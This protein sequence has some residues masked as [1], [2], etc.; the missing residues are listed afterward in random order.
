MYS[1]G[2]AFGGCGR[3][4]FGLCALWAA[5]FSLPPAES[6]EWIRVS[7]S[8]LFKTIIKHGQ[9]HSL[10]SRSLETVIRWSRIASIVVAVA[11]ASR[12]RGVHTRL[13]GRIRP[14]CCCC[15]AICRRRI[16]A[17]VRWWS[18]CGIVTECATIRGHRSAGSAVS[19]RIVVAVGRQAVVVA[20]ICW[21]TA[22]VA[23]GSWWIC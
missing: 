14:R 16:E 11:A 2:G 15:C 1:G 18:L 21:R 13:S 8:R 4:G 10:T 17:R 22:C 23:I 19:T 5:S 7:V 12:H 3:Y 20:R 6:A 9:C